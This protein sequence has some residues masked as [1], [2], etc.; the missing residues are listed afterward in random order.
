MINLFCRIPLLLLVCIFILL[1]LV[2]ERDKYRS[3]TTGNFSHFSEI[4]AVFLT[5]FHIFL[6]KKYEHL[7]GSCILCSFL[8]V[9]VTPTF[10]TS[11]TLLSSLPK[12]FSAS[13]FYCCTV[14]IIR[15][16][17]MSFYTCMFYGPCPAVLYL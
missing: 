9:Y 5:H 6:K 3:T 10:T 12:L 16:P 8:A 7:S 4:S 17:F 15:K 2:V 13:V 11:K 1:T 14:I